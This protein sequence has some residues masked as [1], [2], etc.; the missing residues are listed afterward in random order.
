MTIE[1]NTSGERED[2]ALDALIAALVRHAEFAELNE[3]ELQRMC[4]DTMPIPEEARQALANFGPDVARRL[5]HGVRNQVPRHAV[6]SAQYAAMHRNNSTGT[7]DAAT[8]AELERLR[9]KLLGTD[10]EKP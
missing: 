9:K 10:P 7:H 5:N 1:R 3:D 2:H 6:A 4:T 8:E